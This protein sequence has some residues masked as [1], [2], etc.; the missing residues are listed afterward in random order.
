MD[1]YEWKI[2]Y[3]VPT[4]TYIIRWRRHFIRVW[5]LLKE[6]TNCQLFQSKCTNYATILPMDLKLNKN[7]IAF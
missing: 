4:Y 7:S 6:I 1:Y 3:V 5:R 2:I